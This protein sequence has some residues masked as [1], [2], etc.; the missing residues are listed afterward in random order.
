MPPDVR[1]GCALPVDGT[2]GYAPTQGRSPGMIR[3]LPPVGRSRHRTS[4][5]TAE[6]WSFHTVSVADRLRHAHA[7][8]DVYWRCVEYE[9]KF[10]TNGAPGSDCVERRLAAVPPDV[11]KGC[12]LPAR[13]DGIRGYAP[14][15]GR[16]PGMIRV[17]PPV[18]R[19]RH[20]TSGG[21]AE[22]WSFHTVSVATGCDMHLQ[23]TMF[24]GMHGI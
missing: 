19:S 14:T 18:G 3:V 23:C 9:R 21:T 15:Q 2:R 20:P 4:G 6:N 13:V 1:K 24:T 7:R 10:V 5:G 17:L 8:H 22:N 16:S 11:R 12:A